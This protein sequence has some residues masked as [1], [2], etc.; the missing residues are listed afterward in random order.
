M[1]KYSENPEALFDI[2]KEPNKE[3]S[4]ITN[5]NVAQSP[6]VTEDQMTK[7]Q[8]GGNSTSTLRSAVNWKGG[9]AGA[10]NSS[11]G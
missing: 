1:A 6:V 9:G 2:A 4:V 11:K 3:S 10:P 7:S 8:V 5:N